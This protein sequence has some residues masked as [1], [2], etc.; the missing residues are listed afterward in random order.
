[1]P[2]PVAGA[3]LAN[4]RAMTRVARAIGMMTLQLALGC[5]MQESLEL[6]DSDPG[7]GDETADGVGVDDQSIDDGKADAVTNRYKLHFFP[8]LT[9]WDGGPAS[10]RWP[11]PGAPAGSPPDRRPR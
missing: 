10:G 9:R 7:L 1:M 8:Q 2:G 6:E 11:A 4:A 5:A 3:K